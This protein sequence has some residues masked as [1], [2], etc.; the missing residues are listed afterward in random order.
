VV[1][2]EDLMAQVL[3]ISAEI[4]EQFLRQFIE[5]A[6]ICATKYHDI[7]YNYLN[8]ITSSKELV[9]DDGGHL[10]ARPAPRPAAGEE[11]AG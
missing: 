11:L 8:G 5:E 2:L 3:D 7:I 1:Y 6:G 10:P 4:R 9:E